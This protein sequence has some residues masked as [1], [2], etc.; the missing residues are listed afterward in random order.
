[1]SIN[2]PRAPR[3]SYSARDPRGGGYGFAWLWIMIIIIII[4]FGW[5]CWLVGLQRREHGASPAPATPAPSGK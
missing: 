4:G 5:G 3:D 1:M 2:D